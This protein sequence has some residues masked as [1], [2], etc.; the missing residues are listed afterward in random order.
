MYQQKIPLRGSEASLNLFTELLRELK[1][2]GHGSSADVLLAAAVL[3]RNRPRGALKAEC[4]ASARFDGQTH[5]FYLQLLTSTRTQQRIG[6]E[7]DAL[8]RDTALK[9]VIDRDGT[10][11]RNEFLLEALIVILQ[12]LK[13]QTKSGGGGANISHEV[14]EAPRTAAPFA[15][16]QPRAA[17]VTPSP[18]LHRQPR[19][20]RRYGERRHTA[21]GLEATGDESSTHLGRQTRVK[22][23][24]YRSEF[25]RAI[26][27][28]SRNRECRGND[29]ISLFPHA[30]LY[31]V[32]FDR[33]ADR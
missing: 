15:V 21:S 11:S 19:E 6:E 7:L 22:D 13:L 9:S 24:F 30:C 5:A 2:S 28:F 33:P 3:W 17:R 27:Q 23:C 29:G 25:L 10:V 16:V 32:S 1:G 26:V 14:P 18:G 20:Q 8:R 4:T 12:L 31:C